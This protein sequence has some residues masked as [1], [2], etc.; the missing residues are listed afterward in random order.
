M[1]LVAS[2]SP[3]LM[4]FIA[5]LWG[6]GPRAVHLIWIIALGLLKLHLTVWFLVSLFLT[7]WARRLRRGPS[8]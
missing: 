6:V 5:G 3:P 4:E 7:L 8:A 2:H 1:F